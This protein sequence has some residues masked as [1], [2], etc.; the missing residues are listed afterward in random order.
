MILYFYGWCS[1][2]WESERYVGIAGA[3]RDAEEH[4]IDAM[5][6]D[7]EQD[8]VISIHHVRVRSERAAARSDAGDE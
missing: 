8:V 6:V 4:A 5:N 2:G 3:H 1:C 7:F